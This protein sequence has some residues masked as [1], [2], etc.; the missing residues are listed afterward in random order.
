MAT[1]VLDLLSRAED[2]VEQ[3]G[4]SSASVS[5]HQWES[6][7]QTV[8]RLLYEL[9]GSR[10]GCGAFDGEALP[11]YRLF[12]DY[13]QPL[14]PADDRPAF[15]PREVAR[16]MGTTDTS[17]R[18]RIRSGAMTA[19]LSDSGYRIP[20]IQLGSGQRIP[21]ADTTDTHPLART[22]CSLGALTDLL[23]I[24]RLEPSVPP[25]LN[26]SANAI[27]RRTLVITAT[28]AKRTLG[29]CEPDLADRPLQIARFALKSLERLP[30]AS[31]VTGLQNQAIASTYC[32]SSE[33]AAAQLEHAI[34]QWARAARRELRDTV[35]SVEV[36][37]DINRQG[38]HMY[39]ALDTVL[40]RSGLTDS[41]SAPR[42]LLRDSAHALQAATHVWDQTSTGA[43]PSRNYVEA[44]RQL[45]TAL[46]HIT[47]RPVDGRQEE[48]SYQALLRGTS[49]VAWTAS[50]AAT[51]ASRLLK[52]HVLFIHAN[53]AETSTE[54]LNAK[55]AG[56][57]LAATRTD[58][59]QLLDAV[60]NAERAAKET[61][62]AL[63]GQL[64]PARVSEREAVAPLM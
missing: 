61:T 24:N 54:R 14:E 26:Q 19:E 16:F 62:S 21:P 47:T 22:A 44:A 32:S 4:C 53:H 1:T 52:S 3:L 38:V 59:P 2:S 58:V 33:S 28:A 43:S 30:A 50:L 31:E 63:P 46:T 20:R 9:L 15:T 45:F 17:I 23:A 11:L 36:L 34:H 37:K 51:W 13:P 29:L 49:E 48:L 42:T 41:G 39:A 7:D 18:K 56:R 60:W 57:M 8:Y 64:Q 12:L 55:R 5:R 25:L 10:V 27:A 35:P 6:F 40:A